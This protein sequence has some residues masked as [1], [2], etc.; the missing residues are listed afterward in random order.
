MNGI[1]SLILRW[2][3]RIT[4]ILIAAIFFAFVVG[5]PQGS[6]RA[7]HFR[8]WIGMVLLFGS[9]AAM[10]LAWRWEMP[11]ALV[12]L[13]ALAAFAIVVHMRGYLVLAVAS[14]PNLLFLV[15]WKLRRLHH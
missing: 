8:E 10:L 9:I 3:A 1:A 7:I 15:D 13:V 2:T 11:A 6:L 14:V 5:E 4:A 12:S